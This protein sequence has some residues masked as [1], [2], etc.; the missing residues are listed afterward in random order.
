MDIA[1][2][3]VDYSGNFKYTFTPPVDVYRVQPACGPIDASSRVK[4]IG[5]GFQENKETVIQKTGVY[6]TTDFKS[7]EI[8][9]LAWSESEFLASMLMTSQD[10]LTF[11]Y[12]DKSLT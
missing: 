9:N 11:K 7:S 1:I 10:L 5:T 8:K 3:G 12:V 6:E 2:N 4:L